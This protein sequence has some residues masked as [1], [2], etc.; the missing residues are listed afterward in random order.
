MKRKFIPVE[1]DDR[2]QAAQWPR[3]AYYPPDPVWLLLPIYRSQV[4]VLHLLRRRTGPSAH[5]G[6]LPWTGGPV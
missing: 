5:S 3:F 2:H 4:P 1:A 6:E